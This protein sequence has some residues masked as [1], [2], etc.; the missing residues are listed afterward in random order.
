MESKPDDEN[1]EDL[2]TSSEV[3]VMFAVNPKTVTLW[4]RKGKIP[5]LTTPGGHYRYHRADVEAALHAEK[6]K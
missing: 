1:P 6:P 4:A 5:S 2:L 3:A